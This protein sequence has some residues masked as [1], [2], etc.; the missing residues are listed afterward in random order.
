[1]TYMSVEWRGLYDRLGA[2]AVTETEL[3]E[4]ACNGGVKVRL[5]L[6][7]LPNLPDRVR[8]LLAQDSETP[9]RWNMAV[10]PDTP[11]E[12]LDRLAGDENSNV[13]G[14]VARNPHT[15]G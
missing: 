13:R 7:E 1:M 3:E 2:P 10:N 11:P 14:T 5:S 9:V 4:I 12:T 15:P 6:S 8:D